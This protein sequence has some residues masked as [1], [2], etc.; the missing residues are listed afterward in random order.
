M[1]HIQSGV[2]QIFE[3]QQRLIAS[4]PLRDIDHK[5][6]D[7]ASDPLLTA[8]AILPPIIS[9]VD[10]ALDRVTVRPVISGTVAWGNRFS[11][12]LDRSSMHFLRDL[13]WHVTLT[14]TAAIAATP[15]PIS[16]LFT[17]IDIKIG[18]AKILDITSKLGLQMFFETHDNE[19]EN[20]CHLVTHKNNDTDLNNSVCTYQLELGDK[21][22]PWFER[23]FP[24]SEEMLNQD[25]IV[26]FQMDTQAN[27]IDSLGGAVIAFSNAFLA[28]TGY[29][30]RANKYI[31]W[32][33][34]KLSQGHV[35]HYPSLY[36]DSNQTTLTA[37]LTQH[38]LD[39][40]PHKEIVEILFC[41]VDSPSFASA[42]TFSL[43]DD[44]ETVTSFYITLGSKRIYPDDSG[45]ELSQ[46]NLYFKRIKYGACPTGRHFYRASFEDW[47][48]AKNDNDR[49]KAFDALSTKG[50]VPYLNLTTVNASSVLTI[51]LVS[52]RVIQFNPSKTVSIVD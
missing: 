45:L 8:E 48:Y 10:E 30:D 16:T 43:E 17:S 37:G 41:Q 3:N 50:T 40:S 14:E 19:V 11:Y 9:A 29:I 36:I 42:S 5:I 23:L 4:R 15:A 39:F 49:D 7:I 35:L 20:V 18:G 25:I 38:R 1:E 34:Q 24:I 21:L 2:E 27:S 28:Q 51:S 31:P 47:L 44:D 6:H 33:R 32:F 22:L 52:R 13:S 46:E 26:T 12:K